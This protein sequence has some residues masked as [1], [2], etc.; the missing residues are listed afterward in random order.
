MPSNKMYVIKASGETAPFDPDKIRKTCLRAGA[1]ADLA[2]TIVQKIT[3]RFYPGISTREILEMTLKMLEVE[4]PHVA[5]RYDLKGAIMRLG[6]AG[7]AFE[8]LVAEVL[9]EHGYAT[10]VHSMVQ[11]ACVM[12]E[13]DVIATKPFKKGP[14]LESQLKYYMIECKYHHATGIYTG[15]KETLYTYARFL[16][17]QDGWRTGKCQQ[18]DQAWLATNTK[19]STDAIQYANCKN[20][21]MLG[22]NYPAGNSLQ[23]MLEAKGLYP[24]TSLR[25]LDPP[26]LAKFSAAGMMLTKDL[27]RR[28]PEEI[29][30]KTQ[31]PLRRVKE[32]VNE[33]ERILTK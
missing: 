14:E 18:F 1:P 25:T 10:R 15:L 28:T 16:D 23:D 4:H 31:L 9:K 26:T 6:P 27:I 32:L 19:F 29:A 8:A 7:F 20:I 2:E 33:A 21:K 22:W 12:H 30:D 3:E 11:G 17:L 13:I 5:A 24:I